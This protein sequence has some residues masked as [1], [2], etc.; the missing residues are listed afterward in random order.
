M[1]KKKFEE[2]CAQYKLAGGSLLVY[3]KGEIEEFNYGYKN[4][5]TYDKV[6]SNTI[7]RIASVSKIVIA[8]AIM[9]LYDQK[10]LDYKEDISKYLG[11]KVRNP[12]YK[13]VPITVEMVMTQTSSITDGPSDEDE[14]TPENKNEKKGY[15]GVNGESFP[16][17]LKKLLTDESY[18]YYSEKTFSKYCPG[19][20]FEYSNFG[21]GILS[22]IVEKITGEFFTDYV[23]EN[24]LK[25]LDMNASFRPSNL[26]N[27]E[28]ISNLYVYDKENDKLKECRT[29]VSFIRNEYP[30]FSK[31]DNFRGPAGG[32]FVSINDISKIMQVLMHD[33][34]YNDIEILKSD[35]VNQMLEMHW[36]GSSDDTYKAKGLQ[37]KISD[38]AY[39]YILKGHTGGAYGLRSCLFFN[40]EDDL[41]LCFA[42]NGGCF[43][44]EE[45]KNV[46]ILSVLEKSVF[47]EYNTE[48]QEK[49]MAIDLYDNYVSLNG[50]LISCLE[51]K[52]DD[53]EVSLPLFTICEGLTIVPVINDEEIIL[54]KNDKEIVYSKQN[55][56]FPAIKISKRLGYEPIVRNGQILISYK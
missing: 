27:P 45:G 6:N 2:F 17:S 15:N 14:E 11:F 21:A 16:V 31:G 28:R 23:Y 38:T 42:T 22:C 55:K 24:I 12:L 46:D 33:G 51:R 8:M 3:N 20:H 47:D 40:K 49:V 30:L 1:F 7:F 36:A 32:L 4:I 34:K 39:P 5:K 44:D 25:P 35:T 52:I 13:D 54:R 26:K 48:P 10:K 29:M 18:Q 53:E 19:E 43:M 9:Q 41:G 50:R 56:L 37:I